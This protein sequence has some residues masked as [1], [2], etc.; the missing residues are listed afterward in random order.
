MQMMKFRLLV[1]YVSVG[2]VLASKSTSKLTNFA[3]FLDAEGEVKAGTN[4]GTAERGMLFP[5]ESESRQIKDLGG[6][7]SF[8]ADKSPSRTAGFDEKW[9]EQDLAKVG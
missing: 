6:L 2:V 8:R 3:D 9:Y 4:P 1:F 5:R 7:W